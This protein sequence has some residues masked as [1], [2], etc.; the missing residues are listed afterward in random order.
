M[1]DDNL[2]R[3]LKL[4]PDEP[5]MLD[6]LA[7]VDRLGPFSVTGRRHEVQRNSFFDSS[8]RALSKARVSFRRRTIQGEPLATW[9]LKG[10]GNQARGVS[11]RT[12]IELHL[13]PDM[14]PALAIDACDRRRVNAA[15]RRW[16]KSS[17]TR[18][19]LAA[20]RW[21]GP[22]SKPRRSGRFS[23]W[24]RPIEAGQSSWRSIACVWS[25]TAIPSWRSKPSSNAATKP[26]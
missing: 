21:P 4:R 19:R 11:T 15:R 10:G 12:E 13:D 25:A 3:E 22:T 16:P 9:T 20:C 6:R 7:A 14:A 5:A 18:W 1:S 26:P 17:A 8:S 23:T 2:E 24:R